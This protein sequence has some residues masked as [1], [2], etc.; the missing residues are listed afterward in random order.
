MFKLQKKYMCDSKQSD[1]SWLNQLK[2]QDH[3]SQGLI[4]LNTIRWYGTTEPFHL[5]N[6]KTTIRYCQSQAYSTSSLKSASTRF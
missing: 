1:G 3:F 5:G 4:H 6:D 2:K